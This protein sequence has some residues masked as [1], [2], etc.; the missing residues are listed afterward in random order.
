MEV[1]IIDHN[2]GDRFLI[3]YLLENQPGISTSHEF[4]SRQEATRYLLSKPENDSSE[5]ILI[6]CNERLGLT[7]GL[8]AL[9]KI[10]TECSHLDLF[11]VL[12]QEDARRSHRLMS[13]NIADE[14][15]EKKVELHDFG[16]ELGRIVVAARNRSSHHP[17]NPSNGYSSGIDGQQMAFQSV[18]RKG[19][20]YF[21]PFPTLFPVLLN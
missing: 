20:R 7:D 19:K 2:K 12:M 15:M 1:L 11:T 6:L 10:K 16:E 5:Q 17:R 4:R 13:Q 9:R 14:F 8:E 21:P 18:K 3:R